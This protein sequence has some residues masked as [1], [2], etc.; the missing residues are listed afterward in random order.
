MEAFI[1]NLIKIKIIHFILL[2]LSI[3][4]RLKKNKKRPL[5][6]RKNIDETVKKIYFERK[7]IY[8][9]A[10][11]RIKCNYKESSEIAKKI[12]NLYEKSDYKL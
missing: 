12:I 2:D 1:N 8:N 7:K 6:F 5:L 11:H 3:L 4:K 9:K 10:D